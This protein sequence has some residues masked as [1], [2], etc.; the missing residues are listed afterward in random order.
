MSSGN[1]WKRGSTDLRP[2]RLEKTNYIAKDLLQPGFPHMKIGILLII[3]GI[4]AKIFSVK[5]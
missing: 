3:Q 1:C 4:I 2:L 5:A